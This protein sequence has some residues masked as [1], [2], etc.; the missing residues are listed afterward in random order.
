M[1]FKR[2]KRKQTALASYLSRFEGPIENKGGITFPV[3]V[4]GA[5]SP[6]DY[7][8]FVLPLIV[9]P[10]SQVRQNTGESFVYGIWFGLARAPPHA[11]LITLFRLVDN[12]RRTGMAAESRSC[13]M[14]FPMPYSRAGNLVLK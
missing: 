7:S 5:R 1:H 11:S 6:E 12:P 10:V 3:R 14:L 13:V 4:P 2:R 9:C 8:R